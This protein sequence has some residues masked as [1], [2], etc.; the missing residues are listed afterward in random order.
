MLW[1]PD[2]VPSPVLT[3]ICCS[4]SYIQED[5]LLAT[6]SMQTTTSYG[7]KTKSSFALLSIWVLANYNLHWRI[8]VPIM[9]YYSQ[10]VISAINPWEGTC[11]VSYHFGEL[12]QLHQC[13]WTHRTD[14][15]DPGSEG[16][17]GLTWLLLQTRRSSPL[18][19]E[20]QLCSL[21]DPFIVVLS[22][23][24]LR[25]GRLLGGDNRL[26]VALEGGGFL[27]TMPPGT[28]P[29]LT[30][31]SLLLCACRGWLWTCWWWYLLGGTDMGF[32]CWNVFNLMTSPAA[33]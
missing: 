10:W 2:P 7:G 26:P 29:I 13:K 32:F 27:A 8:E 16:I 19:E 31:T 5:S 22:F 30:G 24:F 3:A 23:L 21:A 33:A 28:T 15:S 18:V 1:D 20:F 6:E 11:R 17:E 4:K 25:Y 12:T 14:I 9:I